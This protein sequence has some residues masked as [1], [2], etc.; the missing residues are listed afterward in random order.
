MQVTV[1]DADEVASGGEGAVELGGIVDFNQHVE[2]EFA[3]AAVKSDQF[4]LGER[5]HDQENG[6]GAAARASSS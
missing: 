5:G 2:L 3:G 1:V 6:V 4:V